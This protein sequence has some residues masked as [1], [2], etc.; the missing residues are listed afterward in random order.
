MGGKS[1]STSATKL[2]EITVSTAALGLVIP[3]VWGTARLKTNMLWYGAFTATPH[4]TKAGGK[5]G[6]SVT[7]TTFTY[8][9]ALALGICSGPISGVPTVYVDKN[10]YTDGGTTA[11]AQAGFSLA[12]GTLGQSVWGWLTTNAP[13]QAIG[14][15]GI[16]YLYAPS[17]S[18]GSSASTPN[19]SMEV[20]SSITYGALPDALASDI[21][22][23]FL[24]NAKD[25][26]PGWPTGTLG[27]LTNWA[28]YC[29]AA[30]LLLS[31]VIDTQIT[32]ASFVDD[33][34]A[35]TNSLPFW[36]EGLLKVMPLGD[37]SVT[38][39]STTWNPSLSPVYTL[40]DS[41]YIPPS[42]GEVPIY[43]DL[44]DQTDA[45]NIVQV[46]FLD[47]TNQYNTAIATRQDDS[48]IA[49]F[50][51]RK[52]DPKTLHMICDPTVA[53]NVAQIILQS[54]LYIRGEY[55]FT[56]P[57]NYALLEQTDLL[58]LNDSGMGL[59]NF[60]V[61]ITQIDDDEF[62]DRNI[63][64]V[65]VPVGVT[66]P[67]IYTHQDS[68]AYVPNLSAPAANVATPYFFNPPTTLTASGQETWIAVAGSV[69]TNWGGCNVW[70]SL[71]NTNYQM[72]GTITNPSR[73][74]PLTATLATSADPDT[75]HT[76]AVDLTGSAGALATATLAD[77]NALTTL[78]LV[79]NELVSYRT[80]NLTS[81]YHYS[82]TNMRRGAM[83]TTIASHSIGAQFVRLDEAPFVVPFNAS[84]A[85]KVIYCKLQSFNSV[86]LGLQDLSTLT[87]YTFTTGAT[88][89]GTGPNGQ[90]A[91][92]SQVGAD[93]TSA[94]TAA[95]IAGQGA[96]A[97]ASTV[98]PST[99]T[100]LAKGS[101]PPT[102]PAGT[103][104]YTSTTSSLALSWAAFTLYRIDGTTV[105]VS[106]GSQSIT[107]LSSG[108]TYKVYPYF[109]DTG[110]TTGTVSWAT[111]GTGAGS[112][113]IAYS[114]SGDAVA[115]ATTF[116]RGNIPLNGFQ[117]STTAS[118]S[119]GGGGGG[120]GCMH[121]DTLVQ[122]D[123]VWVA[124]GRLSVGDLVRTPDG[125]APIRRLNRH[126]CSA[127]RAVHVD[128][129]TE[130]AATVT[131]GHL[132]HRAN[133]EPVRATDLRLGDLLATDGDH[134][135]VTGLS[136]PSDLA[137]LVGIELD[138][139]HMHYLGAR[140]L[141]SHNSVNK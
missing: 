79:D 2:A 95:N 55:H 19:V 129:S 116:S 60:L 27:S 30:N 139:P 43:A 101:I 102:L 114:G 32:A 106:S 36:S 89:A 110:G 103:F 115:A 16:A 93:V 45:Y 81:A 61:R 47:R 97:T 92:G 134:A 111:G 23:D 4:T 140:A 130:A 82:L 122:T 99:A 64:A 127:W 8:S 133:G 124:A 9:A 59:S 39:N 76:L 17:Y 63:T 25:G 105:A 131:L 29:A 121:P 11:V 38:A 138:D 22:T 135:I 94:N 51:P 20:K 70:T 24:T 83:G 31:P 86:G 54:T 18:L 113:A 65:E 7:S 117:A 46:E 100:L 126:P 33:L 15:S 108:T 34:T 28:T 123:T 137:D 48:N 40:T 112:P 56:L 74:G 91:T 13:T 50:G 3:K 44:S 52:M 66:S 73:Y 119:G 80:A 21:L 42:D 72:V 87:A 1:T 88:A 67:P 49:Q 37:A 26:V 98:D 118:G 10:V 90:A 125:F 6:P 84:Q 78:C 96:L 35:S 77:E 85:G 53:N 132:F 109:A 41:S 58:A 104:T 57:W 75:T 71:D 128:G 120:G 68:T 141:L 14:Y 62:G 12:T 69:P 107:G 5:G 136:A